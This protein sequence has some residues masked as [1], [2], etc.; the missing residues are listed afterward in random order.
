M[1]K[2]LPLNIINSL[3]IVFN[4]ALNYRYFPSIWKCAKLLP[5][6]KKGK[7]PSTPTSYR[8]ISLTPNLSK[9]YEVQIDNAIEFYCKK[10][11]VIPDA[12]FGFQRQLS[13]CHALNKISDNI[14]NHLHKKELVRACLID[15]VK[16]FD[17]TW[18]EGLIYVLIKEGFPSHLVDLIYNMI[19]NKSFVT[20]DGKILSSSVARLRSGGHKQ[21]DYHCFKD[22]SLIIRLILGTLRPCL[23]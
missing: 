1:I 13:T 4:N 21:F 5:I 7:D 18:F 15:I 19:L 9:I 16:A 10:L 23:T 20:W 22:S 14:Q 8:P 12:Q 6:L 2:H 3:L 11:N 17:S